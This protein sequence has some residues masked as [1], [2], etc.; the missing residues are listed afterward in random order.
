MSVQKELWLPAI[1][2][3]FFAEWEKLTK[4]AKDDSV[5]VARN[6]ASVKVYIPNAGANG[7][8]SVN[9]T[10]YPVSVTERTDATVEYAVDSFQVPP[11]RV[12]R[13]DSASLTYDK[14]AS[15]A[16]DFMG[17]IGEFIMFNSFKNWY[18]GKNTGKYVETSGSNVAGE[19]PGAAGDRKAITVSD[20]QKAAKILDKQKVPATG[21]ILL[22][23]A[24]MFYELHD[25]AIT[26][27]DI[28]DN[29]GLAM[30]DKEFYGFQVVKMPYVVN[31]TTTG[32]V[33][34]VGHVGATTDIEVGLAY[35]K[36]LVS[37]ARENTYI[38]DGADRPEYY[39]DILSAEAWA[40]AKYRRTDGVGV[41]PILQSQG[42]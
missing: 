11:V 32:V 26:K 5:Y 13:Y 3:N 17:G 8:V 18:P 25:A 34:A 31:A 15:I 21:R 38:F 41:V 33:R 2:D 20:V 28:V 9:N 24:T 29:D 12:G 30:F 7:A 16:K 14:T 23:P 37:V 22:L 10:S 36:D 1:E 4:I 27:F 6:G 42:A 19:A 40:G 35:H 39:G